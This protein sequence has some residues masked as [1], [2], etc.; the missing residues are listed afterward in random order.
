MYGS[1]AKGSFLE[2][3]DVDLTLIGETLTP[4]T[5]YKLSELLEDSYLPYRFDIS[6]LNLLDNP[7]LVERVGKVFYARQ[8]IVHEG[9]ANAD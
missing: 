1:R 3:F 7:L 4:E 9:V 6:V 5:L 2:G 8:A